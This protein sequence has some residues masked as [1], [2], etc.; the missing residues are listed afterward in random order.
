MLSGD[1]GLASKGL[2][3]AVDNTDLYGI[4]VKALEK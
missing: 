1:W 3:R 2:G 4:M